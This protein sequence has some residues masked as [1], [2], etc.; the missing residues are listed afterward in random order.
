MLTSSPTSTQVAVAQYACALAIENSGLT[1]E[2]AIHAKNKV[3]QGKILSPDE[4]QTLTSISDSL[5]EDYLCH[6]DGD[7]SVE[8]RATLLAKFSQS[9]A[10]ASLIFA[11]GQNSQESPSEAIYEA[12]T[13]YADTAD[14]IKK[15]I[16]KSLSEL[17]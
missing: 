13:S 10:I 16:E 17:E 5:E 12:I 14:I 4:I 6:F 1:D 2:F 11:G 8:V 15:I 3:I 7:N 9:R